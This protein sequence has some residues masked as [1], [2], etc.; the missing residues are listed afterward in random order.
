MVI[1]LKTTPY[2]VLGVLEYFTIRIVIRAG[3]P[4]N[5]IVDGKW[6]N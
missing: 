4:T 2:E 5:K 6:K 1:A 3:N